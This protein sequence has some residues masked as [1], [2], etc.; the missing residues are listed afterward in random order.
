MQLSHRI[1]LSVL[2]AVGVLGLYGGVVGGHSTTDTAETY[3]VGEHET[4]EWVGIETV[5]GHPNPCVNECEPPVTHEWPKDP[6]D[7]Q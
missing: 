4:T 7:Y 5:D 2:V 3:D 1:V 6:D